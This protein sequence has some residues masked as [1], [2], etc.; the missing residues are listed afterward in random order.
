[1]GKSVANTIKMNYNLDKKVNILLV[2]DL[3]SSGMTMKECCK[4]LKQDKNVNKIY[5]LAMTRTKNNKR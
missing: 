3:Y 4:V 5:C 2:D 1:M